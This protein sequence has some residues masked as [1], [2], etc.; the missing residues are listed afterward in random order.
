MAVIFS[1]NK[2]VV[3]GK[4]VNSGESVVI[5][6][7]NIFNFKISS[8]CSGRPVNCVLLGHDNVKFDRVVQELRRGL[9]SPLSA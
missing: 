4:G 5:L 7:Y 1:E 3:E 6:K 2:G 9:L 8:S